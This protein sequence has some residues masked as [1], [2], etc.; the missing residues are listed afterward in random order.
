MTT[1]SNDQRYISGMNQSIIKKNIN[2][3][4]MEYKIN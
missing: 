2:P 1:S 4:L 3:Q